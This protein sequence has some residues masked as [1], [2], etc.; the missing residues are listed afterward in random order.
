MDRR[1]ERM[2][3][4]GGRMKKKAFK[5]LKHSFHPSSFLPYPVHPCLNLL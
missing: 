4:E 5:R 2:K 3:D 1:E